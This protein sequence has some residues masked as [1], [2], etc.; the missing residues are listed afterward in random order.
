[1]YGHDTRGWMGVLEPREQ[2]D[3]DMSELGS[4]LTRIR[5]TES[6]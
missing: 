2:V 5:E 6:E 1:M 3:L 4:V